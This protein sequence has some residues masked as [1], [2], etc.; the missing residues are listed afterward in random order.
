MALTQSSVE[1]VT[2][3]KRELQEFELAL[4]QAPAGAARARILRTRAEALFIWG[5]PWEAF[6]SFRG[7]Q[8]ADPSD[9]TAGLRA[10]NLLDLLTAPRPAGAD[11]S[12]R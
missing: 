11:P 1:R 2:L 9:S 3:F 6:I 5:L 7:A 4:E 8:L 10:D 12:G